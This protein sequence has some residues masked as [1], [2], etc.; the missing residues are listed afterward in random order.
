MYAN[1]VYAVKS[2]ID[3]NSVILRNLGNIPSKFEWE[4]VNHEDVI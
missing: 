4:E 2:T 3:P 1:K